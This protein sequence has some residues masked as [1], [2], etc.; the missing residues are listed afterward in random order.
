MYEPLKRAFGASPDGPGGLA[1][2][3]LASA[4]S[5]VCG[6]FVSSPASMVKVRLQIQTTAPS[7]QSVGHQHRASGVFDALRAVW[8]EGGARGLFRGAPAQ[9]VRV[10]IGSTAQLTSYDVLKS[11]FVKALPQYRDSP[12][13][14]FAASLGAG[15]IV[16]AAMNPFDV[17][18]TRLYNQP[19]VDGRAQRYS[20]LMDCFLKTARAEGVLGLYKGSLAHYARLGPH[21]ILTFLIWEQLKRTF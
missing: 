6:A 19:V 15:G 5:G 8:L 7:A 9:M 1:L 14:H 12:V 16:V 21:T 11:S 18:S 2:T 20:G 10:A 17:V 3:A 13:S 4:S